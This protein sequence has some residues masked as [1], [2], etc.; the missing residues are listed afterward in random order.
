MITKNGAAAQSNV[1][2]KILGPVKNL[3][4]YV[5]RDWWKDI[6]NAHYLKTDADVVNDEA[7]TNTEVDVFQ[8]LL[9]LEKSNKIL[10]LCC[11]Q[12]R[13]SIALAKRGFSNISG[14]DR[15]RY[16]I[17]RARSY[18]RKKGLPIS[19][20]EGDA[21]KLP[22]HE[23]SF[24]VVLILGNS[25]GY[26]ENAQDDLKVLKEVSRILKPNGKIFLDITDGSYLLE[27]FE[28]RSWEWIDKNYF[29]CRERELSADKQRLISR[30]VIT[31]TQ[32]GVLVDQF[33]AERLYSRDTIENLLTTTGYKNITVHRT[34]ET[35]SQRNQDLGM[36]KRRILI[37]SHIK[38]D[39]PVHVSAGR[40]K[41]I[42][43][44]VAVLFGDPTKKDIIKPAAV[45]D[46]DDMFTINELKRGLVSIKGYNY[47]YLHNHDTLIEELSKNRHKIDYV[48]NLCDEGFNNSAR[49]ELHV[50]ALLEM[51]NIHYTGCGPQCLA[52]CYDKSLVRGIAREMDIAVPEAFYIKPEDNMYEIH[53]PFPVIIK[54][55]FGDSSFGITQRSFAENLEQIISAIDEIRTVVGEGNPILIEEFLE[56]K[57]LTI[58]IIGNLPNSYT[59][60]PIIEEDYSELPEGLP[61]LC[62][63]EA[64]WMPDSPYAKLKSIPAVLP[65]DVQKY[66]EESSLKLFERLECKDYCRFDWRLDKNG[67]PKL[68]EVNPNPGWCWDGHLA[69]MAKLYGLSYSEMIELILK[70]AESRKK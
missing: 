4:D 54:P 8:E 51:L 57:D 20:K 60:F 10:D 31:H 39:W 30:E 48:F 45:F 67:K 21:R 16:L 36:M 28:S 26:F 19:F 50:P 52:Y 32:K 23:S 18:A 44:T 3:E 65:D 14:F 7:I 40:D 22:Y 46:E 61:K 55:N 69:K 2:S 12:G 27:N 62:G 9:N 56:G 38:K 47:L 5:K 66:I 13:H 42:T 29:V 25:F 59:I 37:S 6:F 70:A 64:K 43:K 15:S 49:S 11:G 35:N 17:K 24:D 41:T 53:F 1:V 68:L 33:Y 63:Y 58:G 34:L